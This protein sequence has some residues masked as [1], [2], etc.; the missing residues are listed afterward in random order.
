VGV[1]MARH[2]QRPDKKN[3]TCKPCT[4]GNCLRCIDIFRSDYSAETICRCERKEHAEDPS[5][6]QI[7]DPWNG[8]VYMPGGEV[9]IDGNVT[10]YDLVRQPVE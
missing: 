7:R 9:D 10:F 2:N 5:H 6:R 1:K 4:E 3:M 8:T